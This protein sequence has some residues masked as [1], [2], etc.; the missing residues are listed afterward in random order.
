MFRNNKEMV[1]RVK[2]TQLMQNNTGTRINGQ[3]PG[4]FYIINSL[5]STSGCLVAR[6]SGSGS[7]CFGLYEKKHEAEKAKK[8][9]FNK[10]PNAWIKVA[11]IFS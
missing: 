4:K 5:N 9:L 10:F 6:M 8:H 2:A 1:F 7:T 3:T 11:K